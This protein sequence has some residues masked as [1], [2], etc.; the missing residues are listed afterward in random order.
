MRH[1]R[2][3]PTQAAVSDACVAATAVSDARGRTATLQLALQVAVPPDTAMVGAC[4]G[5]DVDGWWLHTRWDDLPPEDVLWRVPLGAGKRVPRL[6][7]LLARLNYLPADSDSDSEE[8]DS[9]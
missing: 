5:T 4:V 1:A 7:A 8:S 3:A 2:V 6:M 9:A